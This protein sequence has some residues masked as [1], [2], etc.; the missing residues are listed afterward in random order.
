MTS[1]E[2]TEAFLIKR[3]EDL[4]TKTLD[5]TAELLN[6]ELKMRD[7]KDSIKQ[8]K[9]EAK[10]EGIAVKE[11]MKALAIMKKERKTSEQDKQEVQEMLQ[12][13]EEQ[14]SITQMVEELVINPN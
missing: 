5:F 6:L 7:L 4:R 11:I 1:R 3:H 8:I 12:F 13:L 14:S 10:V 9:K 2:M